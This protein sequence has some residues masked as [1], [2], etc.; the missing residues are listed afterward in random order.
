[1]QLSDEEIG[2]VIPQNV[3]KPRTKTTASWYLVAPLS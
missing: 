1:M 3:Q 2:I